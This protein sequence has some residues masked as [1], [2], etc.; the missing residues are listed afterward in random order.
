MLDALLHE[1]I[2]QKTDT[3][4]CSDIFANNWHRN[5]I[6]ILI[7]ND[8]LY[9]IQI[10]VFIYFEVNSLGKKQLVS[11]GM[12]LLQNKQMKPVNLF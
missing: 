5:F 1:L 2:P 8:F 7:S 4:L 3:V 12:G 6:N 11:S 9:Q 10:Q